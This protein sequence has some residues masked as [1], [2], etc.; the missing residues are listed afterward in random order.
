MKKTYIMPSMR[1][2]ESE[3]ETLLL[4]DS[5]A[6]SSDLGIGYGGVDEDGKMEAS[7]R[8]RNCWEE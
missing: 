8:H 4:A 7:S 1:M 6:I 5:T 2:V 3:T